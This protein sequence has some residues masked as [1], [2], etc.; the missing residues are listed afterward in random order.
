MYTHLLAYPNQHI[1]MC[2]QPPFPTIYIATSRS[3]KCIYMLSVLPS[4]CHSQDQ[5][6]QTLSPIWVHKTNHTICLYINGNVLISEGVLS[7][8]I[9]KHVLINEQKNIFWELPG[10]TEIRYKDRTMRDTV[11]KS[12]LVRYSD[13]YSNKSYPVQFMILL[14]KHQIRLLNIKFVKDKTLTATNMSKCHAHLYK[15]CN[16]TYFNIIYVF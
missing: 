2:N 13:V 16:A 7:V 6:P 9:L 5:T 12:R 11:N 10:H 1:K 4:T 14:Y 8:R 3:W 15:D